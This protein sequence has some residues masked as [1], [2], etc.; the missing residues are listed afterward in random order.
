MHVHAGQRVSVPPLQHTV[1]TVPAC[2]LTCLTQR[3]RLTPRSG[4]M[5]GPEPVVNWML[6]RNML[7]CYHFGTRKASER[8][9]VTPPQ[10]HM[11]A[12]SCNMARLNVALI[13]LEM[14]RNHISAL[15]I[16]G[17]VYTTLGMIDGKLH[18][19]QGESPRNCT[20]SAVISEG[21]KY[22]CATCLLGTQQRDYTS[23]LH[24]ETPVLTSY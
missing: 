5:R 24:S 13:Q 4:S 17:I 12:S 7:L 11:T 3:A 1:R 2:M 16:A 10:A 18:V 20:R 9:P 14:L 23:Q 22:R 21:H 8:Q 6:T 19:S 15:D